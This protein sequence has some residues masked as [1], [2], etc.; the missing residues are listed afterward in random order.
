MRK[1]ILG[2]S[3][4]LL[5]V[6]GASVYSIHKSQERV[7]EIGLEKDRIVQK[8]T[9]EKDREQA[10]EA[11]QAFIRLLFGNNSTTTKQKQIQKR[12]TATG[13]AMAFPSSDGNTQDT[14]KLY[15]KNTIKSLSSYQRE[16]N[17]ESKQ[18]LNI[19]EL[20]ITANGI[21]STSKLLLQTI[22]VRKK[23]QWLVNNVLILANL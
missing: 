13:Y 21:D 6:V 4:I 7:A 10:T 5:V 18:F 8:N 22:L 1:W 12:T 11:N 16:G 14:D 15:I 17:G 23:A 19:V 9:A 2:M 3:F 20:T